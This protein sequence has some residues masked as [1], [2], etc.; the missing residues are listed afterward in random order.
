MKIGVVVDVEKGIIQLHNGPSMEI[1]L[2]SLI[3]VNIL[4]VVLQH[5]FMHTIQQIDEDIQG[6]FFIELMH[7]EDVTLHDP[8]DDLDTDYEMNE[9]DSEIDDEHKMI[10]QNVNV[11]M[12]DW[13]D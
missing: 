1:K 9:S 2:L 3:I 10:L 5:K 6:L 11:S 4:Q 12:E 13:M 8:C 7:W